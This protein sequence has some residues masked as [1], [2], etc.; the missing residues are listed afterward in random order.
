MSVRGSPRSRAPHSHLTF[1]GSAALHVTASMKIQTRWQSASIR[2]C[3]LPLWSNSTL[4]FL[5]HGAVTLR[6]AQ[7]HA[8]AVELDSLCD[9]LQTKQKGYHLHHQHFYPFRELGEENT[10]FSPDRENALVKA[11]RNVEHLTCIYTAVHK[12][13][14]PGFQ[15]KHEELGYSSNLQ[16]EMSDGQTSHPLPQ[17]W[18]TILSVLTIFHGTLELRNVMKTRVVH[19]MALWPHSFRVPSSILS[20]GNSVWNFGACSHV[21]F[22]FLWVLQFPHIFQKHFSRWIG[23]SKFPFG[24]NP[25][26]VF[27]DYT[28]CLQD[29]LCKW[30]KVQS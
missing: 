5:M 19:W 21:C 2:H 23:Y 25:F 29:R 9:G 8:V 17:K 30:V 3:L 20:S 14:T 11:E 10:S 27:L 18:Y 28:Q 22:R 7:E 24:V 6:A 12:A 16:S 26:G 1:K 15:L 13:L 4:C